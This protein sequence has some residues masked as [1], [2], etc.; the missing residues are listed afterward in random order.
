MAFVK[1]FTPPPKGEK[2]KDGVSVQKD[3]KLWTVL[4]IMCLRL[5]SLRKEKIKLCNILPNY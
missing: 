4:K 2:K 3:Y 1:P 5:A